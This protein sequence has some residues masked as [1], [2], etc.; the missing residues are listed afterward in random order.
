MIVTV[1]QPEHLPWLGFFNK[2]DQ[3][4]MLVLL[5]VVQFRKNYFQNRNRI[6]GPQGPVWLT[7]PVFTK[8]HMGR[9]IKE[10]TIDNK[11]DWR[12]KHFRTITQTYR[13]HPYRDLAWAFIADL[14]ERPWDKLAELNR[15]IIDFLVVALGLSTNIVWASEL[16]VEGSSSEL[17]LSIC[18][19]V[20]A[21]T[22]LAGQSA[23]NYLNAGLFA[24][25]GIGVRQHRFV[26]PI[27]RQQGGGEFQSHLSTLDLLINCGPTSLNVIRSGSEA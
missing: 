13:N 9:T 1:H 18:Q 2:V 25:A 27:Y 15:R 14:H 19:A 8:G 11:V 26:H 7:V 4:D 3:A 17:L 23:G 10:M 12:R 16:D 6:W 5:D 24:A 20:G 21:D 22:Y